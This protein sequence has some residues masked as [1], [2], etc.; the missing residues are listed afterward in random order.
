LNNFT[1]G[2]RE[3]EEVNRTRVA[4]HLDEIQGVVASI[5]KSCSKGAVG[6]IGWLDV[7]IINLRLGGLDVAIKQRQ[8][9]QITRKLVRSKF[10]NWL[11]CFCHIRVLA[12]GRFN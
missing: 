12:K 11:L 6:F 4:G 5:L 10:A 3:R 2:V 9:N 7:I 1:A 8:R